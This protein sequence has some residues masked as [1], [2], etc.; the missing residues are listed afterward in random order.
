MAPRILCLLSVVFLA[1]PTLADDAA[2]KKAVDRAFAY[3]DA[4]LLRLPDVSGTPRKQFTYAVAGLDYLM[5]K[6]TRTK[7]GPTRD[8]TAYLFRYL[9]EVERKT[10]DPENLPPRHGL[11][12]TSYLTQYTWPLSV[13]GLYFA[14]LDLRGLSRAAARDGMKRV[15]KLLAAAQESNGGWG[16][17]RIN[18]DG[19]EKGP[20]AEMTKGMGSY[21]NTLVSSSNCVAICVGLLDAIPGI[22]AGPMLPGARKYYRAA[23]LDNGSFP[24]DPSQRS[25][26][27]AKTNV[28]RTAG[29]LFAW[30]AIGLPRGREFDASVAYLHDNF[31]FLKEG[32][33]SPCLNM[34]HSG[35][36]F[37]MLGGDEWKKFKEA[38]FP[39]IIAKQGDDGGLDCICENKAFGVTCD[40]RQRAPGFGDLFGD[41]QRAYTTSLH[42]FVLLLDK[43]ELK[44]L[45]TRKPGAVITE[46]GRRK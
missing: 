20:F 28:G 19:K 11:A 45:K 24:Y 34:L 25:S 31:D 32:H 35:M 17:G 23:R 42:L 16:H 27:F 36:L 12:S 13:M 41:H 44:V 29:S 2:N 33:G 8:I 10:G 7:R 40:S 6:A 46:S 1:S 30:H 37:H 9:E 26:G 39:R 21:P 43:G 14:E 38:Y 22:D 15:L 18:P 4:K 5:R 3:L